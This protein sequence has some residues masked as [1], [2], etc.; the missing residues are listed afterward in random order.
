MES[1]NNL[2]DNNLYRIDTV[3]DSSYIESSLTD[4]LK[5]ASSS[6]SKGYENNV[7]V[8]PGTSVKTTYSWKE[9]GYTDCSATCLGGMLYFIIQCR[10]YI[11]K[12]IFVY[13]L[14]QISYKFYFGY[15]IKL[16]NLFEEF[17][18]A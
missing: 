3:D 6:G 14:A 18:N 1:C 10:M 12:L 13:Y 4:S 15:S 9:V 17:L 16:Q 8:A 7:K 5:S 2:I 11:V